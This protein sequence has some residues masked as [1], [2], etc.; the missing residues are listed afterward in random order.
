MEALS[1]ILELAELAGT[2]M[3]E[4]GAETYRAEETIMSICNSCGCEKASAL[5]IPTGIFVTIW[6]KDGVRHTTTVRTGK[7]DTHMGRVHRANDIIRGIG[8]RYTPQEALEALKEVAKDKGPSHNT[9]TVAWALA[10]GFFAMAMGGFW[11]EGIIATLIGF[12]VRMLG[13]FTRRL[14]RYAML[15]TLVA[16]L[17]IT[18]LAF[19][20]TALFGRGNA[21][22][23][24]A[25]DLMPLLPGLAITTAARDTMRGDLVSG[26]ARG[27]EALLAAACM[28]AGTGAALW[29]WLLLG[30]AL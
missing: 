12:V 4:S 29:L 28:A 27:V 10:S 23:I 24:I 5:V 16:S 18:L 9:V 17:V 8:T 1:T 6:D 25:G 20:A 2:M 22:S 15:H 3:L 30:G 26:V 7:R 14:D 21:N 11:F 19:A 13:R